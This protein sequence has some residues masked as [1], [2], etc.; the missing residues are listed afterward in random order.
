[1]TKNKDVGSV[2]NSRRFIHIQQVNKLRMNRV[3][4]IHNDTI[5]IIKAVP[6]PDIPK[7]NPKDNRIKEAR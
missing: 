4:L 2:L 1:M 6:G 3:A 5:Y 7:V